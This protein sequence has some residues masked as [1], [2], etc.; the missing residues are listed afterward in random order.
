MNPTTETPS[1]NDGVTMIG[2]GNLPRIP[3]R[4]D[5]VTMTCPV[6]AIPFTPSGRRRYCS[7]TCRVAAHRRRHQPTPDPVAIPA[8]QPKKAIT[9]YQCPDCDELALGEQRCHDC[10]TFMR[11][12]GWGGHCPHCDEPVTI[13]DLIPEPNHT[14]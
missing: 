3:S 2:P 6:C 11:R 8:A 1:R 12:L 5:D 10:G 4:N 7:N 13:N 9:V 14:P